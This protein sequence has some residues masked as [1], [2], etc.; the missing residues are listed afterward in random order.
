MG[1]LST[2]RSESEIRTSYQQEEVQYGP[3]WG[4]LTPEQSHFMLGN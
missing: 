2:V 1:T 3:F 4:N